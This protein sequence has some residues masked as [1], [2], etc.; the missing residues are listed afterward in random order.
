[1]FLKV[2]N[3][4]KLKLNNIYKL[5]VTKCENEVKQEFKIIRFNY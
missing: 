5:N 2:V 4:I 1:M 3:V